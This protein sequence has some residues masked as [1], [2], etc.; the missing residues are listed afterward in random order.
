MLPSPSKQIRRCAAKCANALALAVTALALAPAVCAAQEFSADVV[1]TP[2]PGNPDA[3]AARA[4]APTVHSARLYVNKD[5]MRFESQG[6]TGQ[7]MIVDDANQTTVA[8]FPKQ[9]SYQPLGSR[10]PQYFRVSDAERA[11]PDWQKAV[12]RKISC[13]KLGSDVVDGRRSVKYSRRTSSGSEEYVWIDPKLK[14]V[15]KWRTS[16]TEAQ[17]RNIQQ[18]PQSAD[19]FAVPQSYELLK[20]RKPRT[21][22]RLN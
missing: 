4:V 13:E 5:L 6:V 18:G 17:L 7:T 22:S 1:L 10:P 9:K 2:V 20:P 8:L 15:I 14:Y 19:L 21:A 16:Q 12:G 11:C 3:G